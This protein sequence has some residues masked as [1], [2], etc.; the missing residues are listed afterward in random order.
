MAELA[1]VALRCAQRS[2]RVCPSTALGACVV[3]L[4]RGEVEAFQT[5]ESGWPW[6]VL[7]GLEHWKFFSRLI[8]TMSRD[9]SQPFVNGGSL[10]FTCS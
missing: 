5:P 6:A 1:R 10:E 8:V 4:A 7:L 2:Y 3:C 9:G